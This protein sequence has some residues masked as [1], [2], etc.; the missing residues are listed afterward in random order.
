M[1]IV[2]W[3]CALY[4]WGLV[5]L[6]S[7][8]MVV[9]VTRGKTLCRQERTHVNTA[10]GNELRTFWQHRTVIGFGNTARDRFRQQLTVIGFGSTAS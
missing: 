6:A 2:L 10:F 7:L 3:R 9:T 4:S 5:G 1:Q 8:N